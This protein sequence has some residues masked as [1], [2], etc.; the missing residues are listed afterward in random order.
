MRRYER[1]MSLIEILVALLFV[2]IMLG[3]AMLAL[4]PLIEGSNVDVEVGSVDY[5]IPQ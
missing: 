2:S 5:T 4:G 3:T 1:G